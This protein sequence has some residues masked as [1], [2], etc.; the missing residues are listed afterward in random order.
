MRL[1][2]VLTELGISGSELARRLGV[3]PAYINLACSGKVN[4]SIRKCEEVARA[5][6][7]PT[8][9]LFEGYVGGDMMYCPYC[10]APIK[11]VKCESAPGR[12]Q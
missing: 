1:K 7:I 3:T 8:A 5:L 4:L 2:E 6:N 9:M 12:R 11:I 10:G